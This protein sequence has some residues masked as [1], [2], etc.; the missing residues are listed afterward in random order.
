[1]SQSIQPQLD[2][3]LGLGAMQNK[4]IALLTNWGWRFMNEEL[5]METSHP[6]HPWNGT[7]NWR[8]MGN[9]CNSLK[10]P[11]LVS[12]GYG[13]SVL[14]H[15]SACFGSTVPVYY[16]APN[17]LSLS[18]PYFSQGL[19]QV[20]LCRVHFLKEMLLLPSL[21]TGDEKVISGLACLFSEVGQAVLSGKTCYKSNWE[22]TLEE[23][24]SNG[25]NN[26]VSK[27]ETEKVS[28]AAGQRKRLLTTGH[29]PSAA[30]SKAENQKQWVIKNLEVTQTMFDQ[31][32][33]V[34][35]LAICAQYGLF[36]RRWF[37]AAV[38]SFHLKFEQWD[39][40]KHIWPIVMEG[41]GGWS[42]VKNLPLDY[43]YR[44]I[45]ETSNGLS[46]KEAHLAGAAQ[47]ST[48]D[49]TPIELRPIPSAPKL[50][51]YSSFIDPNTK[52][53]LLQGSPCQSVDSFQKK[54]NTEIVSPCSVSSE[55][56]AGLKYTYKGETNA[57]I[58]AVDLI[59]LYEMDDAGV[60]T[61][62]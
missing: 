21:S 43:W 14:I 55:E 41:F 49:T 48:K 8:A 59:T 45:S 35:K 24:K 34:T 51:N 12:H 56:S 20:L 47:S 50:F 15:F 10:S 53:T 31:L 29:P 22:Q 26:S 57:E 30:A 42:K 36:R 25:S 27:I 46:I 39:K 23:V 40:L 9:S 54:S 19:P 52:I 6:K 61:T 62:P 2:E 58:E 32:W 28:E 5:S 60:G 38:G 33:I 37:M 4:N 18:I 11:R 1:M 13:G 7:F 17:A 44:R 16:V 3:G